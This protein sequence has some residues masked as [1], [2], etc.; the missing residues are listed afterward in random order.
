MATLLDDKLTI[1][2]MTTEEGREESPR[3]RRRRNRRSRSQ[4][5]EVEEKGESVTVVD[6]KGR[7]SIE[8]WNSN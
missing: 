8:N 6:D 1:K 2:E 7:N 3:E 5:L 4:S